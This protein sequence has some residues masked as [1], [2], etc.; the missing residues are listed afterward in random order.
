MSYSVE[1]NWFEDIYRGDETKSFLR[2]FINKRISVNYNKLGYKINDKSDPW[3]S[4][5]DEKSFYGKTGFKYVIDHTFYRPRD[6]ILFFKDINTLKLEL[7]LRQNDIKNALL[8]RYATAMVKDLK[9][10]FSLRFCSDDIESAFRALKRL[11][12]REPFMFDFLLDL[13]ID[14]GI[15][16]KNGEDMMQALFEYSLIGNYQQNNVRFKYREGGAENIEMDKKDS[17]ILHYLL[18]AYF[19]HN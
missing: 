1:L 12:P 7:P 6:L 11:T 3:T 9:G 15:D 19:R 8:P 5:V 2:Q 14:E 16:E 18:Q 10:E 17:F 13:I 4:F